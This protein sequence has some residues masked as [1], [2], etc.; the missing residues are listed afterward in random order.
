MI[1]CTDI[2]TF[3]VLPDLKILNDTNMSLVKENRLLKNVLT[4][5]IVCM[6]IYW[7]YQSYNTDKEYKTL[8]K[9]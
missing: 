2:Q 8:V 6:L 9:K 4:A 5:S 1:D 7:V 3:N